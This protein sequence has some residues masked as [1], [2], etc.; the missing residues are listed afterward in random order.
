M[1][2]VTTYQSYANMT[3][4]FQTKENRDSK[5]D[6]EK[7]FEIP[8]T[9]EKKEEKETRSSQMDSA[10]TDFLKNLRE[11]GAAKFLADLNQ[12]KI[13]KLVEEYKQKLID[14]M[15]DSPEALQEIAKLVEDF[16]TKLIEEMKDKMEDEIKNTKNK[17][18][19]NTLV[20]SHLNSQKKST[21]LEELLKL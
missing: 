10:V 5:T 9:E 16:K 2:G 13:D 3:Q 8:Y 17:L 6:S 15:G 14:N 4:N 20:E 21:P 19:G 11:K 12:E 18:S 1:Q 7:K